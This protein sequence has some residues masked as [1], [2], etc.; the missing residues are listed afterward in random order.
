MN[1]VEDFATYTD[2]ESYYQIVDRLKGQLQSNIAEYGECDR[3]TLQCLEGY[4]EALYD[5]RLYDESLRCSAM[6]VRLLEK[7][8]PEDKQWLAEA[9]SEYSHNLSEPSEVLKYAEKAFVYSQQTDNMNIR[10]SCRNTLAS[11]YRDNRMY[12]K[13]KDEYIAL[14]DDCLGYYGEDFY[15]TVI[16]K[17]N[18]AGA[19]FDLGDAASAAKLC[20][21]AVEWF[22]SNDG[23]Q[24]ADHLRE[25][26]NLARYLRAIRETEEALEISRRAYQLTCNVYGDDSSVAVDRLEQLAHSYESV[27]RT[28]L[29]VDAMQQVC[30]WYES[31][32]FGNEFWYVRARLNLAEYKADIGMYDD[33]QALSTLV[34]ENRQY[35]EEELSALLIIL[36]R[37]KAKM[38]C[39]KVDF[40]GATEY[41]MNNVTLAHDRYGS[42]SRYTMYAEKVAA[43][44]LCRCKRT[45]DCL[46]LCEDIKRLISEFPDTTEDH[47]HILCI[48]AMTRADVGE[49]DTALKLLS[50]AENMGVCCDE[51]DFAFAYVFNK[52]NNRRALHHA[53]K[54]LSYRRQYYDP[55]CVEVREAE[56]LYND[57]MRKE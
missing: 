28:E 13:A 51:V 54:A 38:R 34:E 30:A 49:R 41:I 21:E 7:H 32:I 42:D 50:E 31:H 57:I 18:L 6:L 5:A 19:Y 35:Y 24:S 26:V 25:L 52:D 1:K 44:L 4:I 36:S 9:Y 53:E 46:R 29:A 15:N 27:H 33:E 16:A 8:F 10:L 40:D 56:Q 11:A 12:E 55:K 47:C 43:G 22:R 3:R 17:G 20:G 23:E 39:A 37:I 48:E 14:Y 45:A 2:E